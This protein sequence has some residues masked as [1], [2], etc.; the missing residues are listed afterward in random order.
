MAIIKL[1]AL[2]VGVR[3]SAGGLTFSANRSGPYVKTTSKGANPRS[4]KQSVVRQRLGRMPELWRNITSAQR[5]D[6]NDYAL[7]APQE[8]TN[9][10]GET[11]FTTGYAWFVHCNTTRLNLAQVPL[12]PAPTIAAPAAPNIN[13]VTYRILATVFTFACYTDVH[14][15]RPF[16]SFIQARAIAGCARTANYTDFR[17]LHKVYEYDAAGWNPDLAAYHLAIWGLPADGWTIWV[18]QRDCTSEGRL[19]PWASE[20]KEFTP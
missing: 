5:T 2:V 6:W 19:G 20:T 18:R 7:A 13:L 3:G 8:L 17:Q 10:L 9:S 4:A 14:T 11:Y 1:G 12:A 15:Y 16:S